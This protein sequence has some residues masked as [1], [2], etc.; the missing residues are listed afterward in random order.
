MANK[1]K[2]NILS[3]EYT[4]ISEDSPEYMKRIADL[5]DRKMKEALERNPAL[6]TSTASVLTALNLA[7]ELE[8]VKLVA[9]E[10]VDAQAVEIASL[11]K[12]LEDIKKSS[13]K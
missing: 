9:R 8:K 1:L 13:A 10:K 2:V 3:R 6:S 11:K 7:D 5:T 4:L 12:Q